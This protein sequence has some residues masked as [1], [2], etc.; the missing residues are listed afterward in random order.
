MHSSL[1]RWI[2]HMFQIFVMHLPPDTVISLRKRICILLNVASPVPFPVLGWHLIN[3]CCNQSHLILTFEPYSADHDLFPP[4][5]YFQQITIVYSSKLYY[6]HILRL[7]LQCYVCSLTFCIILQ[8]EWGSCWCITEGAPVS[9]SLPVKWQSSE[10]R[11]EFM[12]MWGGMYLPT[13]S[14]YRVIY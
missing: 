6:N 1:S 4:K 3:V 13:P 14:K 11:Y 10:G 9:I 2:I 7:S 5:M 12:T 8:Q